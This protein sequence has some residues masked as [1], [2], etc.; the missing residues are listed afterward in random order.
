MATVL[1]AVVVFKLAA[2]LIPTPDCEEAPDDVEVVINDLKVGVTV[3]EGLVDA[4][5]LALLTS[6]SGLIGVVVDDCPITL[7]KG[8][9][10]EERPDAEEEDRG[11]LLVG[12]DLEVCDVVLEFIT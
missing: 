3:A 7:G 4:G 11:L 12:S 8:A 5:G 10:L 1:V 2:L 9:V 6:T